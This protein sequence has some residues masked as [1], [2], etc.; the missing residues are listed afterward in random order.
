MPKRNLHQFLRL[1]LILLGLSALLGLV[2]N[3]GILMDATAGRLQLQPVGWE[4]AEFRVGLGVFSLAILGLLSTWLQRDYFS[5]FGRFEAVRE[6]VMRA[7]VERADLGIVV[8]QASP[9]ADA[10]RLI[11]ANPAVGQM[12]HLAPAEMI[13]LTLDQI[14]A[15]VDDPA[16]LR[17]LGDR[18]RAGHAARG[19][20]HLQLRDGDAWVETVLVPLREDDHPIAY[21]IGLLRDVTQERRR[22]S[23]L[24]ADQRAA[25]AQREAAMRLK[26]EFL[27]IVSHELKTPLSLILGYAELLE[28]KYP[29]EPLL[30]GIQDGSRRLARHVNRLLDYSA[31]LSDS[32]PLYRTQ[33]CLEE[34]LENVR[35]AVRE[36]Y[37]DAHLTLA[38]RVEP[39]TPCIDADMRRLSEALQE[40][41]DN[42]RAATPPGGRVEVWAGACPDGVLIEVRDTGRG[43][44][45]DAFEAI[46]RPF[47]A[48]EEHGP[49]RT[50]GLGLGLALTRRLIAL[51][52]GRV[53]A[54]NLPSGGSCF[55]VYLPASQTGRKYGAKGGSGAP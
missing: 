33:T 50:G 2:S 43:I 9:A 22:A 52:G 28:E 54:E 40:L 14:T 19:L 42:A 51:H 44:P 20:L 17:R 46:W 4:M 48:A 5:P 15:M 13:G 29:R 8:V 34:V 27:S 31:L 30:T 49:Q 32:L 21:W 37:A 11:Y 39:D 12:L 45:C 25:I 41:L 10:S 35:E 18:T 36:D 16:A 7:A 23:Q 3:A 26:S 1:S 53:E 6:H 24:E 38:T 55:R 47:N